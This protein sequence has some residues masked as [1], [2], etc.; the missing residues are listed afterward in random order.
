LT[1]NGLAAAAD[2]DDIE[3]ATAAA[4]DDDDDIDIAA[5]AA[6]DD[7]D[8]DTA[9]ADFGITS[10]A[11]EATGGGEV[12]GGNMAME[13]ALPRRVHKHSNFHHANNYRN[14]AT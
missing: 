6:A 13:G 12:S 11:R 8:T 9:A 14:S 5:A 3:T 7:D 1:S 4:A 2:D 10:E